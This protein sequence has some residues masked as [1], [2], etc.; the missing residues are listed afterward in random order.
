M[1]YAWVIEPGDIEKVRAC[2]VKRIDSC[3]DG[4]LFLALLR[5]GCGGDRKC[6]GMPGPTC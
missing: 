1:K 2:E 5:T 6:R 4:R 3:C